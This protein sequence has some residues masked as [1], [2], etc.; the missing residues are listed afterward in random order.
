MTIRLVQARVDAARG[1]LPEAATRLTQ[2]VEFFDGR[3]MK[4]APLARVLIVRADV[5]LKQGNENAAIA[6]AQRAL[7]ISRALQGDKP[8]SSLTGQ[9][10]LMLARIQD[11]RGQHIA[12]QAAASE[13]LP[14]LTETLGRGA[15]RHAP[16]T[17]V[18]DR[19]N[20]RVG[21]STR[22]RAMPS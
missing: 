13:A 20:A 5:Y 15:S 14:Q 3:G 2:I 7:E 9:S 11:S 6:D 1:R 22:Q 21:G 18:R 10:L 19:R 8:Y 17:A 16:R 4:V 12:A